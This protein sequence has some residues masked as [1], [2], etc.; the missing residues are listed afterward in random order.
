MR[1]ATSNILLGVLALATVSAGTLRAQDTPRVNMPVPA[2]VH[3]LQ[4]HDVI[5][6]IIGQRHEL[7]LSD[8][9]FEELSALHR[10][11]RE[12]GRIYESTGRSKPPY[13]RPVRITTPEQALAKV[14]TILTPQQQHAAL[15][16]FEKDGRK[17]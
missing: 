7:L 12:E 17:P 4:A 13:Q 11:V 1:T 15:M 9:Q 2:A 3:R 16:L 14:F 10:A 8:A 5:E 6:Q